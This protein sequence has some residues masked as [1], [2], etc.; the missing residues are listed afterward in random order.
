MKNFYF[1]MT[2]TLRRTQNLNLWFQPENSR[3][4][5]RDRSSRTSWHAQWLSCCKNTSGWH[6]WYQERLVLLSSLICTDE[7]FSSQGRV[8]GSSPFRRSPVHALKGCDKED[9]S[10]VTFTAFC[11]PTLLSWSAFPLE[12]SGSA[13]RRRKLN[14]VYFSSI[15]LRN[16]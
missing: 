14:Q 2:N 8:S 13:A 1:C 11:L 4:E 9:K 16:K 6:R 7:V 5:V 15:L 10:D 12:S 3:F